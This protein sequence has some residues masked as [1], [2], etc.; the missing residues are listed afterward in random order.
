MSL[1]QNWPEPNWWLMQ[2][3]NNV[4]CA[5]YHRSSFFAILHRS[6]DREGPKP[7]SSTGFEV[8]Q[9]SAMARVNFKNVNIS[10]LK[11]YWWIWSM[12]LF[13]P[14]FQLPHNC[15]LHE[16]ILSPLQLNWQ[17]IVVSFTGWFTA[18][19]PC[20]HDSPNWPQMT[21]CFCFFPLT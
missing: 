1:L 15:K 21:K 14:W 20:F 5:V 16:E 8:D 4:L 19:Q 3:R 18:L 13:R 12:P 10:P 11:R 9:R 2:F 7:H 6:Q 17:Y